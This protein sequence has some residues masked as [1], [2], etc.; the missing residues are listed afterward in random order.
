MLDVLRKQGL[1]A[2]EFLAITAPGPTWTDRSE[3]YDTA[4]FPVM[5][6]NG[7]VYYM[8]GVQPY[9]AILIDKKGRLVIT[10]EFSSDKVDALLRKIRDL[11]AE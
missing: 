8:F 11:H 9:D 2:V 10:D 3:G 7:G 1:T 4:S 6:D 5:S